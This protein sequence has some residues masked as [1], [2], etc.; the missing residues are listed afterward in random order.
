MSPTVFRVG[1]YRAFFFSREEERRHVHLSSPD[2]EAKFWIEPIL[3]LAS[4]SGLPAR[5]LKKMQVIVEAHHA[6]IVRA[7]NEHFDD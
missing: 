5:E 3:A 4:H 1:K 2:G 6:E 7:W